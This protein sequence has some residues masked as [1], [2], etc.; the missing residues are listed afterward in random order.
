M[1]TTLTPS[2]ELRNNLTQHAIDRGVSRATGESRTVV[3]QLGFVELFPPKQPDS[4]WNGV[5]HQ[6]LVDAATK[7][8]SL[9]LAV[10]L[11]YRGECWNCGHV[12][13]TT[14]PSEECPE[15]EAR[16]MDWA[17]VDELP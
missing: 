8:F 12:C 2:L 1:S 11:I 14:D 5:E 13:E 4:D 16:A 9:D 10:T 15:C 3:R 7:E 6:K 17:Q